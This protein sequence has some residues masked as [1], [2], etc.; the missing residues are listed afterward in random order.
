MTKKSIQNRKGAIFFIVTNQAFGAFPTLSLLM[1]ERELF[2]RERASA[3]YG[4]FPYY[5]AR[6]VSEL[7][8]LIIFPLI[9]SSISYWMIGFRP[10]ANHFVIF[11]LSI[12]A[13][14]L[15]T[16][17]LFVM[18]GSISPNFPIAQILA[19]I[20]LVLFMLFGGF[21]VNSDNIPIYYIWLKY[22]SFFKYVYESLMVNEFQG[23]PFTCDVTCIPNGD[24]QLDVMGMKNVDIWLNLA[25]LVVMACWYRVV[26]FLVILFFHKELK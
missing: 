14:T 18:V 24:V 22:L 4:V 5:I 8:T 2:K 1:E 26:G 12:V 23:L 11:Y 17:S 10:D 19:P 3:L 20:S 6:F 25:I 21:L 15:T 16:S 9:F 7:P 13:E